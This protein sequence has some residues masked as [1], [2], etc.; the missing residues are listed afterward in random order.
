MK[1]KLVSIKR[2]IENEIGERIDTRNRRRD[3]TYAR[4]VFCQLGRDMGLSYSAIGQVLNR[5][6]ATTMHNV[7]V[8][9]PFALREKYYKGMYE[10]LKTLTY[11]EKEE[12]S[13][14]SFDMI[15]ELSNKVEA[16]QKDNDAMR[17]KLMLLS[18]DR[19][20]FNA[21]FE[22][23]N[24]EEIDEVHNKMSIFVKAIKSRVYL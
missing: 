21:L 13:Q 22:G 19:E 6:H 15:K 17:Y 14:E 10:T 11:G 4:S 9:L 23:L 16:L 1:N 2:I 8:I 5:D 3:L 7:K 18:K 20:N 24:E 12:A